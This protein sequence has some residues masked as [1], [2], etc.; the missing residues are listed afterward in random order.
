[1]AQQEVSVSESNTPLTKEQVEHLVL[2]DWYRDATDEIHYIDDLDVAKQLA[3]ELSAVRKE[4]DRRDALLGKCADVLSEAAISEDGIDGDAAFELVDS[5]RGK[6]SE[7]GK[8]H[9]QA[10]LDHWWDELCAL[11]NIDPGDE[12]NPLPLVKTELA[13]VRAALAAAQ[14][15]IEESKK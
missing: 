1:V 12:A 7:T 8:T 10:I 3:A 9:A 4:L 15:L 2:K 6:L 5:I 14:K 13:T 11:V